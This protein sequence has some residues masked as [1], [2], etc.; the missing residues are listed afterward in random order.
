MS[1]PLSPGPHDRF[2]DGGDRQLALPADH[3]SLGGRSTGGRRR[4]RD[5]VCVLQH[6]V[7][8]WRRDVGP[9]STSARGTGLG[10]AQARRVSDPTKQPAQL[11][12]ADGY[13]ATSASATGRLSSAGGSA[14]LCGRGP[15]DPSAGMQSPGLGRASSRRKAAA[16]NPSSCRSLAVPSDY[17]PTPALGSQDGGDRERQPAQWPGL[18]RCSNGNR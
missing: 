11:P 15:H 16:K 5:A 10:A 18:M 8:C 1:G 3:A 2:A 12:F 4:H 14:R 13:W 7:S 9:W 17:W 6:P